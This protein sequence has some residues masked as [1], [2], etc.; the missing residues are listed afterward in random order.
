MSL[1][2]AAYGKSRSTAD[3]FLVLQELFLE[4]RF[5]KVGKRGGRIK[6]A[7][8]ICFM[9][10]LKAFD[11]VPREIL[12]RKLYKIG[13]RGRMFRVIKDLYAHNRARVLIG[14]YLTPE[15]EFNLEFCKEANLALFFS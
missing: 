5:N 7:L 2:Q 8:Y 3:H 4:Y 1:V 15:F 12:C 10:L 6:R 14:N 11:N 9:D 13:V